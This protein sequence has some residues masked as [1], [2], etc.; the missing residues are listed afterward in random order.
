VRAIKLFAFE[1]SAPAKIR[2]AL[3]CRAF[4]QDFERGE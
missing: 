1:T 2:T 3:T 4:E